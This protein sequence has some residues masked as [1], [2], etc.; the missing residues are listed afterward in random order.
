[1]SKTLVVFLATG[2]QG[3][4]VINK[5]LSDEALSKEFKVRGISRDTEL[6]KAKALK[7]RGVDMVTADVNDKASLLEALKGAHTVF[8]GIPAEL[9]PDIREVQLQRGKKVA[10]AAVET[11]VQHLIWST[12]TNVSAETNGKYTNV[13][14][15]EA[16]AL[17]EEYIRTLPIKSLFYNPGGFMSNFITNSKPVPKG[18]GTY[19]ISK[20]LKPDAPVYPLIDVAKDSGLF[21]APL[22]RHPEKYYGKVMCGA[23]S[24]YTMNQIAK[25]MSDATGKTVV[26]EEVSREECMKGFPEL[27]AGIY[28]DMYSYFTE[29]GYF[30]A[31]SEQKLQWT[32]E[33]IDGQPGSFEEWLESANVQL[34]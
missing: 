30:G 13:S 19:V 9:R 1:M 2:N 3:G 24:F 7:Q 10:D 8:A 32:L 28:R 27:I 4:S 6:E 31:N 21:V 33:Q 34:D 12:S 22:L 29:V 23:H 5:V 17:V 20:S 15:F 11:G 26:Y 16:G 14:V 18:D 25:A